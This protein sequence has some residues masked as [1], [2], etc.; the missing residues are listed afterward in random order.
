[1]GQAL[2][3]PPHMNW[4]ISLH[5]NP[6]EI[7]SIIIS[8]RSDKTEAKRCPVSYPKLQSFNKYG[9]TEIE[10]QRVWLQTYMHTIYYY[11]PPKVKLKL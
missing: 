2:L 5:N 9:E 10:I 7:G 4:M 6:N 1:M 8:F 3:D 11:P